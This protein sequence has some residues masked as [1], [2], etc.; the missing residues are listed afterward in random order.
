MEGG[1]G[2]SLNS[3]LQHIQIR[4]R[5]VGTWCLR[6]RC[7]CTLWRPRPCR[8]CTLC[9][10]G[11]RARTVR[12]GPCSDK[13]G[14][15]KPLGKPKSA[16]GTRAARCEVLCRGRDRCPGGWMHRNPSR[17]RVWVFGGCKRLLW[18]Q[19]GMAPLLAP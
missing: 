1:G 8:P 16:P 5:R 14:T 18:Q 7:P 15:K 13:T 10:L 17:S 6:P 9:H 2:C 19:P 4:L 12:P 11:S 3:R